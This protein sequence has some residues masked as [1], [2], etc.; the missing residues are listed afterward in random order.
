MNTFNDFS[1]E[2]GRLSTAK[3]S[4]P[5]LYFSKSKSRERGIV[6]TL[7]VFFLLP[8]TTSWNLKAGYPLSEFSLTC[9]KGSLTTKEVK[10]FFHKGHPSFMQAT[11]FILNESEYCL[12][13]EFLLH[14]YKEKP[15]LSSLKHMKGFSKEF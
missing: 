6:G 1:L 5:F 4:F 3:R 7:T 12:F 10:F 2:K 14:Y 9:A 8:R 13:F 15:F 11:F